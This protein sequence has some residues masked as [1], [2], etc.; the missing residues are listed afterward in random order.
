VEK[1]FKIFKKNYLVADVGGT[2]TR[3]CIIDDK[4][5]ILYK[6][7]LDSAKPFDELL[8]E[9]LSS[10]EAKKYKI[11][12]GCIAIAGPID[13]ERKTAQLTNNPMHIDK[14]PIERL[15]NKKILLIN[16]FEATGFSVNGLRKDQYTELTQSG[17]KDG[18]IA[19][20]G[21]GTGLGM[22]ILR[23]YKNIFIPYASE[24]GHSSLSASKDT[25]ENDLYKYIAKQ[26]KPLENETI[27]SGSGILLLYDFF[28]KKRVKHN[29]KIA[30][31]IKKVPL[32]EKPALITKYALEDKDMLCV[33][34]IDTFVKYYAY[35]SRDLILT[36]MS[37]ELVIAG[38]IAPRILPIFKESFMEYFAIH[39][40]D[41]A[42]KLLEGV[43]ILVIIDPD[44]NL[45]GCLEA[46]KM[47][48][49]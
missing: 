39:E 38:G 34:V 37:N 3:I 6:Q 22:S 43:T 15:I 8:K 45:H 18:S 13:G 48:K 19:V 40:R 23:P 35:A 16:D 46:L 32:S 44:I 27:L 25:I 41:F 14:E 5:E 1:L 12:S 26:K 24:G 2:N 21:A 29:Q 9:F 36:S 28:L 7:V 17:R 31:E 42:R 10:T 11:N 30:A 47:L 33:R 4:H 49:M 20:I